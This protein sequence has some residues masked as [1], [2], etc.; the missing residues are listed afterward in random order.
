VVLLTP[1]G[2]AQRNG[3]WGLEAT[4]DGAKVA[5]FALALDIVP[6]LTSVGLPFRVGLVGSHSFG[7]PE[8][9]PSWGVFV[10]LFIESGREEEFDRRSNQIS[11]VTSNT[12]LS[13]RT[14]SRA[15]R[16]DTSWR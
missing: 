3:F 14:T 5:P 9:L 12:S 4:A 2:G 1:L 6:D 11:T 8:T 15:P 7:A 16:S 10:R 13:P